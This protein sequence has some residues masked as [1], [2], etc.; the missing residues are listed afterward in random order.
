MLDGIGGRLS[1][2]RHDGRC[3]PRG[4]EGR[5]RPGLG[6]SSASSACALPGGDRLLEE[7]LHRVA[8]LVSGI[9]DTKGAR[10]RSGR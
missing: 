8:A 10:L 6:C 4:R 7:G 2:T 3:R 1:R 9:P 5:G